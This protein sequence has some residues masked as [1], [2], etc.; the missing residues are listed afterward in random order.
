MFCILSTGKV[1][2]LSHIT[3]I[4]PNDDRELSKA[5][6]EYYEDEDEDEHQAMIDFDNNFMRN[7]LA[8]LAGH[9]PPPPVMPPPPPPRRQPIQKPVVVRTYIIYYNGTNSSDTLRISETEYEELLVQFKLYNQM[10]YNLPII[11]H[12]SPDEEGF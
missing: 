9:I 4:S 7:R 2:N 1:F 5:V 6:N 8:T 12:K 10:K 11:T 3:F